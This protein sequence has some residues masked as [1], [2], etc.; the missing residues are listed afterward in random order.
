VAEFNDRQ[1]RFVVYFLGVSNGNATDAARRAGY[2]FP[3]VTSARLL[4]NARIR[5]AIEA[6]VTEVA[7]TADEVLSKLADHANANPDDIFTADD[8]G[9][10]KFDYLKAKRNGKLHLIKEMKQGKNGWEVKLHDSQAAL[11]LLG[12]YHNLFNDRPP[13][14]EPGKEFPDLVEVRKA[15]TSGNGKGNGKSNGHHN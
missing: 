12:K 13:A 15:I 10:L 14:T 1:R 5:A 11:A 8:K 3:H 9:N 6:R 2:A 4:A 7:L